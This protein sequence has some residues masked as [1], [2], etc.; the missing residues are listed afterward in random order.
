MIDEVTA[1]GKGC[2]NWAGGDGAWGFVGLLVFTS[3]VKAV[4]C[5]SKIFK[6]MGIGGFGS[7]GCLDTRTVTNM[8]RRV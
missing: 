5:D 6:S 3:C 8:G 1:N 2:Q 7:Y 4:K